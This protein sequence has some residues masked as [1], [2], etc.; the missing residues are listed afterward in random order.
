V[1]DFNFYLAPVISEGAAEMATPGTGQPLHVRHSEA[2]LTSWAHTPEEM[3][4]ARPPRKTIIAV[5]R[6]PFVVDDLVTNGSHP[7]WTGEVVDTARFEGGYMSVRSRS[8]SGMPGHAAIAE[9][10]EG[11]MLLR[12]GDSGER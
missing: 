9:P 4:G 3:C 8:P 2:E 7:D 10:V 6:S 11:F 12:P 5:A 1:T